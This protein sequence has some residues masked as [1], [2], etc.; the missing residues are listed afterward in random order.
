MSTCLGGRLTGTSPSSSDPELVVVCSVMQ[1]NHKGLKTTTNYAGSNTDDHKSSNRIK[2]WDEEVWQ[3]EALQVSSTCYSLTFY[4]K[5][6]S[7]STKIYIY[8]YKI[9]GFESWAVTEKWNYDRSSRSC[10][11]L[12]QPQKSDW[13]DFFAEQ[14]TDLCHQ[15]T[16]KNSWKWR[17]KPLRFWRN[18][19]RV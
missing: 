8:L 4:I 15:Q 5:V 19:C 17:I 10:L 7:L 11:R 13:I 2:T 12:Y 3:I 6:I 18:K 9:P 16:E 14:R 1:N